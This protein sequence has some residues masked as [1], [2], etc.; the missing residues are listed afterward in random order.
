VF[1]SLGDFTVATWM[2]VT[3]TQNWERVF[4]TGK[5]AA[6]TDAPGTGTTYM[7]LTPKD[8]RGELRWSISKDGYNNEESLHVPALATGA[9][10]HVTI[11][12]TGGVGRLY[13]DGAEVMN[14]PTAMKPTDIVGLDYAYLGK[15]QFAADAYFDGM[16]DEFRVYNRA[17]SAAEV[18]ALFQLTAP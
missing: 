3:G 4:D 11:V 13:V 17:L 9:W 1:A 5:N 6:L 10:R 14:D 18:L 8:H 15:S 12:L 16:L 7:N 2:Y